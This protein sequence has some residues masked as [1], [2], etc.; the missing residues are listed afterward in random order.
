MQPK[1]AEHRG[2]TGGRTVMRGR[3]A[4]N[5]AYKSKQAQNKRGNFCLPS[6]LT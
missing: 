4:E 5:I 1:L 6:D 3:E 2:N